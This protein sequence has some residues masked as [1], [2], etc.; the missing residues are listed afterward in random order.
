MTFEKENKKFVFD[1]LSE[2]SKEYALWDINQR[3]K[4]SLY[5][6]NTGKMKQF[7]RQELTIS[8]SLFYSNG[9]FA[10]IR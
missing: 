7:N 2:K 10:G 3:N 9:V 8:G 1:D 6:V 5:L 4:V